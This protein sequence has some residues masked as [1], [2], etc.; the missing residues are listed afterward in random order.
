MCRFNRVPEA[1][2][3]M[4]STKRDNRHRRA[5]TAPAAGATDHGGQI[6]R[7]LDGADDDAIC[8]FQVRRKSACKQRFEFLQYCL[9]QVKQHTAPDVFLKR[10]SCCK[11]SGE[12]AEP[13]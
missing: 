7:P 1:T 13:G 9:T 8:S 12:V 11:Q 2:G 10:L 3:I 4:R 6:C 5:V